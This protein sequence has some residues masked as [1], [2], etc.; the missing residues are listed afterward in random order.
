MT[1]FSGP[2]PVLFR[3]DYPSN[4]NLFSNSDQT[5]T[6][7]IGKT[8]DGLLLAKVDAS[9]PTDDTTRIK[10]IIVKSGGASPTDT[11]QYTLLRRG[12]FEGIPLQMGSGTYTATIYR[13]VDGTTNSYSPMLAK[14][15]V[16]S[17][18]S[19][20]APYL[21]SS[22][23][24]DFSRTSACVA[25]AN[26]LCAG[27]T[28]AVDKVDVVYRFIIANITYDTQLA[29]DVGSG[30]IVVYVPDP[31]RTLATKKGICFDYSALFA[32]MLRSQG[33]PVRL[34]MGVV[35]TANAYHA[36]NEV[37]FEG[38]GWVVVNGFQWVNISGKGWVR[39]D[40]TFGH[41]VSSLQISRTS[42]TSQKYY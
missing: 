33:I 31:D 26:L 35:G 34:V 10:V 40:T 4:Q 42:Y 20:I 22:Q 18:G 11:Y 37:Y 32:S 21:V 12:T 24:S 15:F 13:R 38:R 9:I 19:E 29:N 27:L 8:G 39:L 25:K 3:E 14:T 23:F 2:Y 6:F 1:L 30:K 7:D 17:L 16:V 5:A 28:S 36:W 41:S